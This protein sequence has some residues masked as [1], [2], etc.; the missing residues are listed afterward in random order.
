MEVEMAEIIDKGTISVFTIVLRDDGILHT[1]I[2]E[3][4]YG[5]GE[6]MRLVPII[7]KMTNLKAVPMLITLDENASP[8]HETRHFWAKKDTCPYT[9]A[10]AYIAQNFAHKLIGNFYLKFNKPGRPTRIFD[11]ER[12]AFQWLQTFIQHE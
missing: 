11:T 10:E 9:S 5:L 4:D 3:K 2:S 7:G 12:E 6:L 1:H 8:S